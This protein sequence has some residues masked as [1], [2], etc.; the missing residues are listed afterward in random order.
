MIKDRA[1]PY[2][3][4]HCFESSPCEVTK[5]HCQLFTLIRMIIMHIHVFWNHLSFHNNHCFLYNIA[6][7][8]FLVSHTCKITFHK[9]T[10]HISHCTYVYIMT[11]SYA[12]IP[13]HGQ[14]SMFWTL[15]FQF[16]SL[17]SVM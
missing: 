12:K 14:M 3:R 16:N 11:S 7:M 1:E 5:F 10:F 13:Q 2:E 8:N 6:I 4:S 17:D 15:I 9:I